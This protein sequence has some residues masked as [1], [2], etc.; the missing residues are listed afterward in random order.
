MFFIDGGSADSCDFD[1]LVRG[2]EHKIF[3]LCHL[4]DP[5]P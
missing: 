4:P 5:M 1:V 2:D 3:L